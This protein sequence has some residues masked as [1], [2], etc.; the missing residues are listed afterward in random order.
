MIDPLSAALSAIELARAEADDT[1]AAQYLRAAEVY[2]QVAQAEIQQRQ[3][4]ALER[5]A[6][7]LDWFAANGIAA[8]TS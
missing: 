1:Q 6:T 4:E 3:L 5:I 2:A 8:V 7:Q